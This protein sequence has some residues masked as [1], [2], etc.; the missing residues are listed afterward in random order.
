MI[1]CDGRGRLSHS[2][3]IQYDF[4]HNTDD[5]IYHKCQELDFMQVN[6]KTI[7]VNENMVVIDNSEMCGTKGSDNEDDNEGNANKSNKVDE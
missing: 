6:D 4:D 7:T 5:F 3:C 2:K 1:G